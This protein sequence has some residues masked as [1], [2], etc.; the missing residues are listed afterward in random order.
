MSAEEIV[1]KASGKTGNRRSADD[2]DEEKGAKSGQGL[3]QEQQMLT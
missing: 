2:S 3:A 1:Q